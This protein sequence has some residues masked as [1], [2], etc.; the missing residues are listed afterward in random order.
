MADH[1]LLAKV[2]RHH[3]NPLLA[4]VKEGGTLYLWDEDFSSLSLPFNDLSNPKTYFSRAQELNLKS[5]EDSLPFSCKRI[6][7]AELPTQKIKAYYVFDDYYLKALSGLDVEF[8]HPHPNHFC[9]ESLARSALTTKNPFTDFRKK[10]EEKNVYQVSH[11]T[12]SIQS[13]EESRA[14]KMLE[15]YFSDQKAHTYMDER[16]HFDAMKAGTHFSI[17]LAQ[18]LLSPKAILEKLRE[19][20]QRHGETKSSYWIRFELLW[21]EFFYF[22][23]IYS[24]TSLYYPD[25]QKDAPLEMISLKKMLMDLSHE[26]LIKAMINELVATGMLSNRCRQIFASYFVH[27]NLYDWRYGAYFFQYF[28]KDYDPSSNWGNWQYLA[29]VGRDP[30]GLRF[31]NLQT[32]TQRYDPASSYLSEWADKVDFLSYL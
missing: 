24:T 27:H 30:R 25:A 1:Y 28:L 18:G 7:I 29:G 14:L 9:P 32:Q 12:S 17:P 6:K 15:E 10:V 2:W 5:L 8:I 13:D 19:F 22:S 31:F 21:R 20:E 11:Q 4:Q 26:P 16:N 3:D 23:Q